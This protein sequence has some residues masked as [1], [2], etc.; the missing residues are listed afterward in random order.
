[1]SFS[2]QKKGLR[3][4]ATAQLQLEPLSLKVRD[5][6]IDSYLVRFGSNDMLSPK[7]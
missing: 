7:V 3:N 5:S 6:H 4:Q 2:T 1:M